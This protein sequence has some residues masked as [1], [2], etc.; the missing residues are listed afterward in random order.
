MSELWELTQYIEDNPDDREKRW[1]LAKKLYEAG[2]YRHA[3]EHFHVLHNEWPD[4]INVDR[5]LAATL[6]RLKRYEEARQSLV[7]SL[8]KSPEDIAL[9]EQMARVL[10]A[11]EDFSGAADTWEKIR[12]LNAAHPLAEKK[13]RKL[14]KRAR[15]KARDAS[16]PR[17]KVPPDIQPGRVCPSCGV[18]NPATAAQCWQCRESLGGKKSAGTTSPGKPLALSYQTVRLLMI[19]PAL[20]ISG[21]ALLTLRALMADEPRPVYN[22]SDFYMIH[23]FLSRLIAGGAMVLIWPLALWNA[24][25]LARP[26]Q[27]IPLELILLPGISAGALLWLAAWT[28]PVMSI[29]IFCLL[30]A[31]IYFVIAGAWGMPRTKNLLVWS[32]QALIVVTGWCVFF[33]GAESIQT[34]IFVNPIR[35]LP[36]IYRFAMDPERAEDTGAVEAPLEKPGEIRAQWK[37]TG[38]PW[39][40]KQGSHVLFQVQPERGNAGL[41]FE[42]RERRE[43]TVVY[44]DVDSMTWQVPWNVKPGLEYLLVVHG[45]EKA[46]FDLYITGLLPVRFGSPGQ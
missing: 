38:S 20:L 30:T 34:G 25:V 45:G 43:G 26:R 33:L 12:E 2:E 3:L 18:Q 28:P 36:A 32:V 10:Q 39:L 24:M 21:A 27:Y 40:D 14:R 5:F 11:A 31:V 35:E 7:K 44:E 23:L 42:I 22:L 16:S 8:V 13:I 41:R 29:I 6:Y 1:L 19:V 9:H 46:G 4:K 15:G 37:S 17:Y